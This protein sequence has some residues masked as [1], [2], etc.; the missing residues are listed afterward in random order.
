MLLGGRDDYTLA[1]NCLA[2][3]DELRARGASIQIVV[4]PDANHRST[5]MRR[6]ISVRCRRRST[7]VMA[8]LIW[9]PGRS[10]SRAMVKR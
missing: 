7:A 1:S 10:G 5:P 8:R 2:Y 3:A 4:Y 9:T 6:R